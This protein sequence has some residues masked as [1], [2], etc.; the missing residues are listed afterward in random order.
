MK[1]TLANIWHSTFLHFS[2]I[3]ALFQ[4]SPGATCATRIHIPTNRLKAGAPSKQLPLL[5]PHRLLPSSNNTSRRWEETPFPSKN[6]SR[7]AAQQKATGERLDGFLLWITNLWTRCLA[8]C[9]LLGVGIS[10]GTF[11]STGPSVWK[12]WFKS[13]KQTS[14]AMHHQSRQKLTKQISIFI[15]ETS[16]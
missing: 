16:H 8:D 3:V 7:S 2:L 12:C 6:S 14:T 13:E 4:S 1:A 15:L 11:Q 9:T 10:K 5:H